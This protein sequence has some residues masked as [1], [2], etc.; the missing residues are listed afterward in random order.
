MN[1]T[2]TL[3]AALLLTPML[4]AANATQSTVDTQGKPLK[5]LAVA[6][7]AGLRWELSRTKDGW[8]LGGI[9]FHEKLVEQPATN[10]LLA[11]A[12]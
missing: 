11:C 5:T 7:K 8:S 1:H 9:S 4:C 2:R 10:G 6:N 12:T 3:L